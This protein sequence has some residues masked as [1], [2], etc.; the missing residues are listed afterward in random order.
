MG[1]GASSLCL[2]ICICIYFYFCFSFCF[3]TTTVACRQGCAPPLICLFAT[4]SNECASQPPG[5]ENQ[6]DRQ[7]AAAAR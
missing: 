2:C 4:S 3:S 7:K 5:R 1:D 6:V